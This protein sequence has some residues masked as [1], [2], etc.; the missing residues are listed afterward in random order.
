MT[1]IQNTVAKKLDEGYACIKRSQLVVVW[2]AA[3]ER[4][5]VKAVP[6]DWG[7]IQ[8]ANDDGMAVLASEGGLSTLRMRVPFTNVAITLHVPQLTLLVIGDLAFFADALGKHGICG[9]RCLYFQLK[10]PE[11][12]KYNHA[13]QGK[14]WTHKDMDEIRERVANDKN[15]SPEENKG[16]MG[17]ALFPSLVVDD[18]VIPML[19]GQMGFTNAVVAWFIG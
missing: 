12:Q 6:K 16:C 7:T 9:W 19:H 15:L 8:L 1:V 10:H 2:N 3:E 11:W 14:V 18:F 4:S 5:I 17:P 13:K